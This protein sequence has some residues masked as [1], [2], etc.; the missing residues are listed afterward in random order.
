METPRSVNRASLVFR[1]NYSKVVIFTVSIF[2]FDNTSLDPIIVTV[3]SLGPA[4]AYVYTELISTQSFD[5][6]KPILTSTVMNQNIAFQHHVNH[7]CF[8]VCAI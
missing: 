3:S 1:K 4:Q 5:D 6:E 7:D 2:G 8:Q